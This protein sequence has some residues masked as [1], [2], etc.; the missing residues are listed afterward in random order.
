MTGVEPLVEAEAGEP[1]EHQF[2]AEPGC[3][4]STRR[5]HEPGPMGKSH[6]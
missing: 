6:W 4:W 2:D 3:V 5:I 1:C